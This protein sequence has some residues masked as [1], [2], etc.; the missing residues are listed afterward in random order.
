MSDGFLNATLETMTPYLMRRTQVIFSGMQKRAREH[1]DPGV[2]FTLNALRLQVVIPGIQNP[3]C[4][5][6]DEIRISESSFEIDHRDS[7]VRGGGWQL[8]NLILCCKQCNQEKGPLS[9]HEFM[10]LRKLTKD[11][12]PHAAQDLYR[13][14]RVGANPMAARLLAGTK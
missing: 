8:K 14:L 1:G 5:Y 6:C 7:L 2:P 11:W 13:R 3:R 9:S 10:A 4:V 12:H